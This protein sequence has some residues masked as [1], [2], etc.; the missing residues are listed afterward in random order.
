MSNCTKPRQAWEGIKSIPDYKRTFTSPSESRSATLAEELNLFFFS[1]F[2][3]EITDPELPPLST[4]DSA[5]VLSTHD[6]RLVFCSINPRKAAGPDGV[7]GRVLKDC[8]AELADV[9]TYI[10]NMSLLTSWV[11]ACFKEAT[12]VPIPKQSNVK[13]LNDYRPVALTSS[14]NTLRKQDHQHLAHTNLHIGRT[15]RLRMPLRLC[16][17]HYW[18]I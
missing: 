15:G 16:S 13:C 8:V 7:L 6:V 11:P 1:R 10:Y 17:T 14:S 5:P 2:D 3:R 18:N 4:I 12:I 9:F